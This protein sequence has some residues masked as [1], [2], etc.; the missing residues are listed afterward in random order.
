MGRFAIWLLASQHE[1]AQRLDDVGFLK[2]RQLGDREDP[3]HQTDS[4]YRGGQLEKPNRFAVRVWPRAEMTMP[5]A[6]GRIHRKTKS[7]EDS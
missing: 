7:H 5:S 6:G 3:R 1:I 2:L 4:P